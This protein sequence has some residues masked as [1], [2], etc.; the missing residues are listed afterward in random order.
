LC[1]NET[2]DFYKQLKSANLNSRISESG[3]KLT[4][5][6]FV[7][8]YKKQKFHQ[9]IFYTMVVNF[10]S[11]FIIDKQLKQNIFTFITSSSEKK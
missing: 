5:L 1:I 4:D 11:A 6:K 2:N 9:N 3:F 10:V 7:K 8:K